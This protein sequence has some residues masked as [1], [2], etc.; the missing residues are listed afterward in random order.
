MTQ[1]CCN[2]CAVVCYSCSHLLGDAAAENLCM[3]AHGWSKGNGN[4]RCATRTLSSC[5]WAPPSLDHVFVECRE[6]LEQ[7]MRLHGR[8]PAQ[9]GAAAPSRHQA[10]R[11]GDKAEA[12]SKGTARSSATAKTAASRGDKTDAATKGTARATTDGSSE[13]GF[14]VLCRAVSGRLPQV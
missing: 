11:G 2:L 13:P 14:R 8:D 5:Y 9:H 1:H 7:A 3:K 6:H 4:W 10:S 12:A